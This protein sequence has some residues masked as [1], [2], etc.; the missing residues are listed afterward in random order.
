MP[1]DP[2]DEFLGYDFAV[3][4][5]NIKCS[6]CGYNISRSLFFEDDDEEIKCPKCGGK[7]EN[8]G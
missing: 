8:D 7:I 6:H 1:D 5:D 2:L 3:G 4:A